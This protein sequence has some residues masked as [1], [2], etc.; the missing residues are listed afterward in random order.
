M[1]D[2]REL[3]TATAL[4][5]PQFIS[6]TAL[7]Q[8]AVADQLGVTATELHC[9]HLVSSGTATSPT[10]LARVLGM[11]TGALTRMLDRME[12]ERLVERVPD[13]SDRRRLS[14]RPLGDRLEE[15]AELYAPMARFLSEGLSRLDRRQLTAMLGFLNESRVHAEEEAARLREDGAAHATRRVT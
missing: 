6:A 8:A 14:I 3:A 2:L 15:L 5:I 13:P 7:F 9:L 11:T 1:P 10:E 12:R 4:E